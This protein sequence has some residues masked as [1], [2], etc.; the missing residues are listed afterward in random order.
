MAHPG[1]NRV[2]D[3]RLFSHRTVSSSG[4]SDVKTLVSAAEN[5]AGVH[6]AYAG[7]AVGS[8]GYAGLFID[9]VLFAQVLQGSTSL[10]LRDVVFP[11]GVEITMASRNGGGGVL[12]AYLKVLSVGGG[13]V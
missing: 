7:L 9:G 12:S 4:A 13:D 6:I 1:R 3:L 8:D 5:V 10:I 11:A 2:T